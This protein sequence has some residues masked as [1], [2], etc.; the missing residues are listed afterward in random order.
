[1]QPS[2]DRDASPH[3]AAARQP[4]AASGVG[5][6]LLPDLLRAVRT[7]LQMEVAFISRI[8]DGM[9]V[10]AYVDTDPGFQPIHAG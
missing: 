5:A 1:M 8:D 7:H 10:F 3:G 4:G 6:E 2:N 9:R